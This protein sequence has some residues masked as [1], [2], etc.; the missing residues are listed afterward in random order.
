MGEK[1]FSFVEKTHDFA[2]QN[3]T[4]VPPYL[5]RDDFDIDFWMRADFG[6]C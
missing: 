2:K 1:T 3:P 6:R 4:L 5:N